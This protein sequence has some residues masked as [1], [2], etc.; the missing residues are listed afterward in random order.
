MYKDFD[1]LKNRCPVTF[2]ADVAID[3]QH[4]A[5][6]RLAELWP[7]TGDGE[8]RLYLTG[9]VSE[10]WE[11]KI[12][13]AGEVPDDGFAIEITVDSYADTDM[14]HTLFLAL[15]AYCGTPEVGE[16]AW[17]IFDDDRLEAEFGRDMP[18]QVLELMSEQADA[19]GLEVTAQVYEVAEL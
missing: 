1:D 17:K 7:L 2:K 3:F 6:E 13:D 4:A 18:G 10:F 8:F 15:W 9:R 5:A 12:R 19:T 14:G 16:M 11:A